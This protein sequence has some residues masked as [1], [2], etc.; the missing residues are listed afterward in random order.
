MKRFVPRIMIAAI[1]SGSGKTTI[2]CALLKALLE[3]GKKTVSF[4]CGP[5]YIDPMFHT[6]V[7]GINSS[8][9]DLFLTSKD[10][11]KY[12]LAE[13]SIGADVSV[14]EGVMGYYDGISSDT[15]Y[16]SYHLSKV[17]D[18]PVVLVINCKGMSCTVAAVIEGIVNFKKDSNIKGIILNNISEKMYDFYRQ[19]IKRETNVAVLGYMPIVPESSFES[20]HLGLVTAKETENLNKKLEKLA[21][22]AAKTIDIDG[23]LRLANTAPPL[24]YDDISINSKFDVTIAVARDKAFCFYYKDALN[25]LSR[26][27]AKIE[28]FSPINDEKMP[29]CDGFI[30]GGGYPE[31]HLEALSKNK[32]MLA[33]IKAKIKGGTPYIAE[34]GGFMYLFGIIRDKNEDAYNMADVIDGQVFMTKGLSRFGYITLTALCDN[35]LCKKGEIINAHE[36]HYSDSTNNGSDFI[37][38]KPYGNREWSCI[39]ADE[40]RFVGYPHIHLLGNIKYAENFLDKCSAR[41]KARL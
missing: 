12:L 38:K 2:T 18:T 3:K 5:D 40:Q 23:L 19:I 35:L 1:S 7:L 13:S 33:D 9:L 4:K 15:L 31:I 11:C 26:I 34:C 37:A 28:Y 30:L 6:E 36:F 39:F 16:S 8:N 27:G 41:K 21:E 10:T 32:S 14:I 22:A 24:E 20:R 17:T 25:L 29:E